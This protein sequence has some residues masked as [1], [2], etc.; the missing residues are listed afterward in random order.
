[1]D[2][3]TDSVKTNSFIV[4]YLDTHYTDAIVHFKNYNL[5]EFENYS[6][7]LYFDEMFDENGECRA[8]YTKMKEK[9]GKL[10]AKKIFNLQHSTEK[11][12]KSMGMT[13]NVYHDNKGIEKILHLDLI[14]RIIGGEEWKI[15]DEG[16][17]QRI[18]AIN[19]FLD[20]IYNDQQIL[21]DGIVPKDMILSSQDYLE[22]CIGLKPP[23]GIWCHITGSDIVRDKQ[24]KFY[25]LEDNLRCP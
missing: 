19:M 5:L 8:V 1:M 6:S 2:K 15:I 24:G 17:Q 3:L 7:H 20:D 9:I 23:K 14:P 13:F 10:S 16:L 11:A 21:K 25:V 18:R 22:P 4:Y 12:Q